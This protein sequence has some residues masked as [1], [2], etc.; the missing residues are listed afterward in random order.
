MRHKG[1]N[2]AEHGF[3]EHLAEPEAAAT[4]RRFSMQ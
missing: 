3:V 1:Y 4:G 2:I